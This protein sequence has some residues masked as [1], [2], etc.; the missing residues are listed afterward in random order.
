MT[1]FSIEKETNDPNQANKV[2]N[3]EQ[4]DCHQKISD[5]KKKFVESR[6]QLMKI[7]GINL[8][9]EAQREKFES[10]KQQLTLKRDL[11]QRYKHSC[12]IDNNQ[13][14]N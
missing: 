3:R 10:L 6:D 12:P 11:L 1:P 7:P 4:S 14:T 8:T 9:R 13:T 2:P 5:L